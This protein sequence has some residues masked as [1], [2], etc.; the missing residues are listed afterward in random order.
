MYSTFNSFDFDLPNSLWSK[1]QSQ[2][3]LLEPFT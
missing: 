1:S 3:M 2:I